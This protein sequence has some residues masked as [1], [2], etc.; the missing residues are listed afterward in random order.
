MFSFLRRSS[1]RSHELPA[2]I[3][4]ALVNDGLAPG[5]DPNALRLLEQHGSY[6][7]RRVNFFRV[8]DSGRAAERGVQPRSF[9]D[10]DAHPELVLAAG[11]IEHGGAVALTARTRSEATQAPT[12]ELADRNNH[13]DD[14]RVVFPNGTS[15]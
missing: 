13:G 12:R 7:G 11:H 10:L 6:S 3:R 1:F 15:A 5:I 9:A 2:T 14:D 8:F 4:M